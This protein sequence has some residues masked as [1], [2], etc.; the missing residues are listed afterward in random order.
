[1][2]TRLSLTRSL[3]TSPPQG[4]PAPPLVP[5]T[6]CPRP[7]APTP[8]RA[9]HP[10]RS[11]QEA[12]PAPHGALKMPQTPQRRPQR[13]PPIP[14]CTHPPHREPHFPHHPTAPTS[15][16]ARSAPHHIPMPPLL[17]PPYVPHRALTSRD[18]PAPVPQLCRRCP[19][20]PHV[21]AP[22]LTPPHSLRPATNR[23]RP[24]VTTASPRQRP[25]PA[26]PRSALSHGAPWRAH[27]AHLLPA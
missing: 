13:T 1:M 9:P 20:Q 10:S 27:D 18:G 11:P 17:L 15:P 19:P 4:A 12:V 23:S 21:T 24:E 6:H 16:C 5:A 2:G 3:A 26:P 7:T 8:K 25:K 14:L 22:A